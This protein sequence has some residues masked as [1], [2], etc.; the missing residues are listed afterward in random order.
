VESFKNLQVIIEHFDKYPLITAKVSDYLIFK[1]FF[2]IIKQGEH[3]TEKG[4]LKIV[5]LKS[6][7]NWGLSDKILKSFPNAVPV[8]R[9]EYTFKGIT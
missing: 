3:L 1:T 9:P 5:G 7:L 4:L 8:N 6:S 2:K